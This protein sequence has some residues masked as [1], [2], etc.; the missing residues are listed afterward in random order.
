MLIIS[1]LI[2]DMARWCGIHCL[3]ETEGDRDCLSALISGGCFWLL[4]HGGWSWVL[5]CG[6][7]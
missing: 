7:W 5:M 4:V 3:D 1:V 6:G 2:L